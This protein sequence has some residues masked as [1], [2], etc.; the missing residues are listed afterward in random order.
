MKCSDPRLARE[1]IIEGLEPSRENELATQAYACEC[2]C[3]CRVRFQTIC[4]AY[5][6][7]CEAGCCGEEWQ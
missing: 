5:C 6:A 4:N 3:G 1:L 7:A 2:G